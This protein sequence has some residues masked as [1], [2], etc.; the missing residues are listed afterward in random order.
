MK[1]VLLSARNSRMAGGLFNSVRN[2]GLSLMHHCNIQVSYVSHHD[3]YHKEDIKA[4]KDLPIAEYHISKLPLLN[5]LGFS[6]DIHEVLENE[7]PDII[8]IQGIW[9][10]FS[11]AALRY[12]KKH[13]KT[14]IIIAP[15]GS[16]SPLA[17]KK[18]R[19]HK[20]IAGWFYENENLKNA[21]CFRA[22]CKPEY[23]NIRAL[24]FK[25]P[26]AIIPNGINIPDKQILEKSNKEKILL[27]VG[28][29]NPIKGLKEFIEGLSMLKIK[30]P[31]LLKNWKI[32][33]AG[34]DQKGHLKELIAL[35]NR[36]DLGNYVEFIGPI[37]GEEKENEI[38]Q[39]SAFILPS[40]TEAMPMAVLEAWAYQLPVIMTDFCN[41]SEGFKLN[42]AIRVNPEPKSIR[43]GLATLFTMTDDELDRMGKNGFD[44]VSKDFTWTHIAKQSTLLYRY[45]LK[46]APTPDFLFEG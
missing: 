35:V 46:Q 7:A 14:K 24:G 13:P 42:A 16:L 23:D 18:S 32:R 22:L 12:K 26:V 3:Q 37:F 10:Y 44:M 31:N 21:D 43:E 25:N 15:R 2:L 5:R 8:E 33:I 29:I 38:V 6:K 27:Y 39:A 1:I 28:R 40:F 20:T 11:Y 9:M 19:L 41:L 17:L 36:Y 4:Y 34:W 30:S 45:L